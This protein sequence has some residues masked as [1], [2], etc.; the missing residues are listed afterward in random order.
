MQVVVDIF[1][2]TKK[3]NQGEIKLWWIGMDFLPMGGY[4]YLGSIIIEL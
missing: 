2:R 3:Y 4:S 1:L